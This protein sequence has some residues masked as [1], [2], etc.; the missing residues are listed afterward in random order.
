MNRRKDVRM[1]EMLILNIT[2]FLYSSLT[3]LRFQNNFA[4]DAVFGIDSTQ[5][6]VYNDAAFSLVESVLEGYNGTIFAYGQ[7]G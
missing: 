7:T 4:Y 5:Q 1:C 3:L 6:S 2:R